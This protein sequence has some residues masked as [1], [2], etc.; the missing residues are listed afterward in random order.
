MHLKQHTLD[1]EIGRCRFDLR[2]IE[3]VILEI[4]ELGNRLRSLEER[5]DS[6]FG[7]YNKKLITLN[8]KTKINDSSNRALDNDIKVMRTEVKAVH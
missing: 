1:G 6:K 3:K 5:C 2:Q 8:E 7:E 4:T